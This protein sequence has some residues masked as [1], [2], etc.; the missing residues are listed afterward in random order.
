MYT[1]I[2]DLSNAA[3]TLDK[4]GQSPSKSV[5]VDTETTGLDCHGNTIRLIQLAVGKEVYLFDLF[6]LPREEFVPLFIQYIKTLREKRVCLTF[7]NYSFDMKFLWAL[8]IDLTGC[9]VFDTLIAV[10]VLECGLEIPAGLK[11]TLDRHLGLSMDK[12]EQK[13]DW[14]VPEL[15]DSQLTYAA[16]DPLYLV[17]LAKVLCKKLIDEDLIDTFKLEMRA[18]Y[19]FAA[20]EYY[21]IKLDSDRLASTRPFY[22]Q[23]LEENLEE[24]LN[25][26]P[27]R[28]IRKDLWGNVVDP[29]ISPTSS[30]Q[31]LKLLRDLEVPNPLYKEGSDKPHEADPIIPSTGAPLLKLLDII[32]YPIVESLMAYK[33]A[34]TVLSNYVETL[35][36]LVNSA[37]NRVHTHYNQILTTGRASSSG[38][39]LNKLPR[40][41]GKEPLDDNGVPMSIRSC[42]VP[43][44]GHAFVMADYCLPAGTKV[45]TERGLVPIDLVTVNDKVYQDNLETK[46]V[47]EVI[48]KGS[49]PTYE[50]KTKMGYRLRATAQH[51]IKVLE[52]NE[53]LWK[54][55]GDLTSDSVVALAAG[56]GFSHITEYEQLP[57]ITYIHRSRKLV[58]VPSTADESL[59]EFLGYITGDGSFSTYS[60]KWVVNEQDNDLYESLA[61]YAE[62]VFGYLGAKRSYQGVHETCLS[63]TALLAW[64]RLIGSSKQFAPAF[65]FRSPASVVA[66]YLRGLFESD[67]CVCDRVSL[68]TTSQVLMEEVHQLLLSLGILSVFKLVKPGKFAKLQAY[69]I[70]IPALYTTLFADKVGF[71][72]DRKKAKLDQLVAKT[73]RSPSYG[74]IP[75][76]SEFIKKHKPSGPSYKLL[77]NSITLGRPVSFNTAYKLAAQNVE[78]ARD[79]GLLRT[80]EDLIYYDKVES[81]TYY[82]EEECF[83][84]SIA[85]R[86]MYISEGFVS[87]NS[88]IELRLMA[89]ATGDINML[90]EFRE[91]RDPYSATAAVVNGKDYYELVTVNPNG[92]DKVK[93][94][95]KSLRQAAKAIRLG[96][97]YCLD[98]DTL[99][100]TSDGVLKLQDI[101]TE[102]KVLTHL[103]TYEQ[104]VETQKVSTNKLIKLT[105]LTGKTLTATVDHPF[106]V[107]LP[108]TNKRTETEYEWVDAG[109]L[110]VGNYLVENTHPYNTCTTPYFSDPDLAYVVGWFL[111]E[112]HYSNYNFSISQDPI[113]NVDVFA[114][115]SIVLPKFGFYMVP[116]ST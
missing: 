5:G 104:V 79:L 33:K 56:R 47:L 83:D 28:Y 112:G 80:T 111:A 84:L 96:Y 14:S 2:T 52:N 22:E 95:Y 75:L 90:N 71:I 20:M 30:A 49:L 101:T 16:T 105:T 21:G 32:K 110:Q 37:T 114:R 60:I 51:R 24:F 39:N 10:K 44:E 42:F 99:V 4:L 34:Y 43:D 38:P 77:A 69:S 94:E 9:K 66:A 3:E 98:G 26:V 15:S 53:Y 7:H 18:V 87:H 62:S 46:P 8:G 17:E 58:S 23:I 63:S 116:S 100:P 72:S 13:S 88:Q 25:Q 36:D 93:K 107:I 92:E 40:P 1:Y 12:T 78:L 97:N 55:V 27:V 61:T 31:V 81:V 103:G 67:G 70:E 106:Q 45:A 108:K 102:H 50:I 64:F 68:C 57:E 91:E 48:S 73:N 59:A 6:K 54:Q 85:D 115:M 35:P 82:G 29:G 76:T 113:A 41:T 19:G 89:H 11:D 86:Q 74:S 65:L 109:E